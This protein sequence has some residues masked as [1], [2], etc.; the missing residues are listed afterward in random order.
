MLQ[1]GGQMTKKKPS[2]R[3]RRKLQ[4]KQ[5][6]NHTNFFSDNE[7]KQIRKLSNRLMYMEIER[8]NKLPLHDK[9]YCKDCRRIYCL[10]SDGKVCYCTECILLK[11]NWKNCGKSVKNIRNCGEC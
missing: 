7:N 5:Q 6:Q 3:K 2:S 9:F 11:D 10:N 8:K 4:K 1:Q